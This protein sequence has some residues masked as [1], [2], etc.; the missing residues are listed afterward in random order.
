[1]FGTFRFLLVSDKD[2]CRGWRT[3]IMGI[4]GLGTSAEVHGSALPTVCAPV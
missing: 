1:M 2:A 3:V 4:C